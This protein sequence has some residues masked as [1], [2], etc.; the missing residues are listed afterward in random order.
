MAV[1]AVAGL[2]LIA[3][4]LYHARVLPS[5][6]EERTQES[7]KQMAATFWDVVVTFFKKPNVYLILVLILLYRAGEGQVV[8]VGPLFLQATRAS[9]G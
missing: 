4:G 1:F 8:K 2:I 7:V 6:G 9:G 3:L 5:G